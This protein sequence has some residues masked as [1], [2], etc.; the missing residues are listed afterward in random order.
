M[1]AFVFFEEL[2]IEILFSDRREE[3]EIPPEITAFS[4]PVE[5]K[6]VLLSAVPLSSGRKMI[7][8]SR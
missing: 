3:R 4:F 6:T 5:R 1:G 7:G 8:S 2:L